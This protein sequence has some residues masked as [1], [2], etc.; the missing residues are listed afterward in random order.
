MKRRFS[1]PAVVTGWPEVWAGALPGTKI[2][3]DA[4]ILDLEVGAHDLVI[5]GM[6]LH[7][8]DDAV[9][10]LIQAR[11][12]LKPD[13]LFLAMLP[14]GQTLSELRT[15]LA[16]AEAMLRGGLSPRVVP[17]AEI[18]DLGALLQRAGFAL[19]VADSICH[20]VT[21]SGLPELMRDLRAM[22]EAN[23]MAARSRYITCRSIFTEAERHYR[24]TFSDSDG[25]LIATFEIIYL[26]GW[27]P[28]P[29]QPT[30]LRPGSATQ[31]L[32][33]ALNVTETVLPGGD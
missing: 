33:D 20:R 6:A 1:A 16:A 2:V 30:P 25:R 29:G 21:Y 12:A 5:H 26:T 24:D 11:R 31:R 8:A 22:G 23:A 7:W 9:S 4:E 14:G 18:R 10:Q 27:A 32:A 19:P 3:E 28:D 15:A 17:M 13:G